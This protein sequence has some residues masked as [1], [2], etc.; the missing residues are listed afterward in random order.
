[1][2]LRWTRLG[3]RGHSGEYHSDA[4]DDW[5]AEIDWSTLR[6]EWR[7]MFYRN[8]IARRVDGAATVAEAKRKAEEWLTR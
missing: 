8:D 2:A 4:I 5:R 6:N 1:M 7:V 3:P